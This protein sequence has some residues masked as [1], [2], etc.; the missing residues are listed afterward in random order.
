MVIDDANGRASKEV[1]AHIRKPEN[2]FLWRQALGEAMR[3][4]QA[5]CTEEKAVALKTM[6]GLYHRD[7][8]A[9]FA[10][11]AKA[12]D[13]AAARNR[14]RKNFEVRAMEC[15]TAIRVKQED[16]EKKK[17]DVLDEDLILLLQ[18]ASKLVP[19]EGDGLAW[20]LEYERTVW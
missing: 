13:E 5:Q 10:F 3:E 20:H 15:K 16:R 11:Q 1:M 19:R 14:A 6:A 17:R 2:L 7:K 12:A 4:L 8:N 18:K 9:Y